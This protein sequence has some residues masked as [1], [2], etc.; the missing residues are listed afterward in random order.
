MRDEVTFD[1]FTIPR[2][3]TAGWHYGTDRWREGQFIRY[4]IDRAR[5]L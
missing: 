3:V 5:Y 4:T 1:G 2:T